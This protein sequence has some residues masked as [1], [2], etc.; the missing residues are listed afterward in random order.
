MASISNKAAIVGVG[1]SDYR[2]LYHQRGQCQRPE[3]LAV[4][5][6]KQ[7]VADAGLRLSDIDG[8]LTSGVSDPPTAYGQFAYRAGMREVRY[9]VPLLQSGRQG[10]AILWQAALALDAGLA[11]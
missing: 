11:D 9:L 6:L 10:L 5:A 7:A 3:L 4:D 1:H 8:L 2:A